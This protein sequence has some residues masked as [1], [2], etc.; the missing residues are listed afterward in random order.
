MIEEPTFTNADMPHTLSDSIAAVRVK[1]IPRNQIILYEGDSPAEVY[2]IKQGIVKLHN[3]DAQGSEHILHLLK[4]PSVMPLAAFSGPDVPNHWYYTA[5]TDCDLYVLQRDGLQRLMEQD[6]KV[7]IYLMN[8]FSAEVHEVLVRLDSLGKTNI[9]SKLVVALRFLGS[10]NATE[11]RPGWW[12]VLFPVN[13]QLLADL[14]G[15]SRESITL[16]MKT[17]TEKKIVRYPRLA[18][19]EINLVKLEQFGEKLGVIVN[20]S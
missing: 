7:A 20:G 10:H 16:A 12:Q 4:A 2:I 6:G 13:H 1:H 18:T 3:I 5:L 8:K 15:M 11:T 9:Q 19:L 17:L 14:I